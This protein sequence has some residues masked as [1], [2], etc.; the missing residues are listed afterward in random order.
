MNLRHES[1]TC[2][3]HI[4]MF[5]SVGVECICTVDVRTVVLFITATNIVIYPDNQKLRSAVKLKLFILM[6]F[7]TN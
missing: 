1:S 4:D 3:T 7:L 2:E 6:R 5:D